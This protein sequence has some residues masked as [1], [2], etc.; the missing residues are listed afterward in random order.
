MDSL[1]IPAQCCR[2]HHKHRAQELIKPVGR[3]AQDSSVGCTAA[4]C[5]RQKGFHHF[6]RPGAEEGHPAAGVRYRQPGML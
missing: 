2:T 3:W 6:S 1:T 5:L 4:A